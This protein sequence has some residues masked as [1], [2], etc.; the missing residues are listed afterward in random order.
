[1]SAHILT[2]DVHISAGVEIQRQINELL[3][4]RYN[5]RHATLQLECVD[6]FPDS[7]Y[8]DLNGHFH[9]DEASHTVRHS[10]H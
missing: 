5:I 3:D 8:C 7:L 9:V 2:D 1:M 4:H 10:S 6:C